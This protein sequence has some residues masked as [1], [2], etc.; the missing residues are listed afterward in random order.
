MTALNLQKHRNIHRKR[1]ISDE[2][3]ITESPV[4][5]FEEPGDGR[6]DRI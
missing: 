5:R 4:L 2:L 1:H 3:W 6:G